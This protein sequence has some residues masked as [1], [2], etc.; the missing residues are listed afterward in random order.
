MA[1]DG[2]PRLEGRRVPKKELVWRKETSDRGSVR[3]AGQR[4][5]SRT[6]LNDGQLLREEKGSQRLLTGKL[7][8]TLPAHLSPRV[9]RSES[10]PLPSPVACPLALQPPQSRQQSGRGSDSGTGSG[11]EIPVRR[12]MVLR[13]LRE[14]HKP[15]KAKVHLDRRGRGL[16][17]RDVTGLA[18]TSDDRGRVPRF[19]SF[20]PSLGS[21]IPRPPSPGERVTGSLT[22]VGSKDEGEE[23]YKGL[24]RCGGVEGAKV[25]TKPP[26]LGSGPPVSVLKT[27]REGTQNHAGTVRGRGRTQKGEHIWS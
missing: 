7:G 19:Q 18:W 12:Q 10:R 13:W 26:L 6:V 24:I 11:P 9:R 21:Y 27:G 22:E 5:G 16:E 25:G 14:M 23:R 17:M 2:G 4:E 20:S 3:P 8:L 1:G 15:P